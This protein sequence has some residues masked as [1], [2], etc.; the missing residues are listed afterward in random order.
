MILEAYAQVPNQSLKFIGNWNNSEFGKELKNRF[1]VF[2]NI[3]LIDP[4]YDLEQLF[5]LRSK[6]ARYIHGHSAGGTNPS[7]VEMMFFDLPIYCFDCN[8]KRA[9]TEDKAMYFSSSEHLVELLNTKN[10]DLTIAKQMLEV[11]KRRYTWSIVKQQYENLFN[12]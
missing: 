1:G 8:Y 6:A 4:I 3:E 12:D 10:E 7:L 9:S 11:S 2:N 5:K